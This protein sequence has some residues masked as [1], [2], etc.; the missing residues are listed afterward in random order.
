MPPVLMSMPWEEGLPTVASGSVG[1]VFTDPPYGQTVGE[2]RWRASKRPVAS[3][4]HNRAASIGPN[5]LPVDWPGWWSEIRRVIRPGGVVVVMGIQPFFSGVIMS[6]LSE[7]KY[8]WI[9]EKGR[10][11][12]ALASK[13]R[14]MTGHI[15]LAVFVVGKGRGAYNPQGRPDDPGLTPKT[16]IRFASVHKARHFSEKPV[17]LVEYFV[18]T[19]SNPGDIVLDPFMGTGTTGVAAVR[20]GRRFIG[21]DLQPWCAE[22]A[23]RRILDEGSPPVL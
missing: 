12:G 11:T 10:V 6:N 17:P 18:R 15:E 5:N 9:W 2:E 1:M 14:P 23:E 21:I 19:Y 16:V 3:G 8:N 20:S 4:N 22:M 7:F 13:T